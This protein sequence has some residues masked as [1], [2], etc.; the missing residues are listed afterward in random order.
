MICASCRLLELACQAAKQYLDHHPLAA[1][2]VDNS[3]AIVECQSKS[4]KQKLG[5]LPVAWQGA[6]SLEIL[7]MRKAS[8]NPVTEIHLWRSTTTQSHGLKAY[9]K[10]W[11]FVG[12]T[13]YINVG[14]VAQLLIEISRFTFFPRHEPNVCL[15]QGSPELKGI[16]PQIQSQSCES[17]SEP[18][19]PLGKRMSRGVQRAISGSTAHFWRTN[20]CSICPREVNT[21]KDFGMLR[22]PHCCK[23]SSKLLA[24]L[25]PLAFSME[26]WASGRFTTHDVRCSATLR[27]LE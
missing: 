21:T 2:D 23:H 15:H 16:K 26:S 1:N 10:V 11:G 18:C 19:P 24:R 20:K 3:Q 5:Q 6:S 8:G 17:D 27:L 14:S 22:T 4:A 12:L 9:L 25:Q 7:Q 13:A